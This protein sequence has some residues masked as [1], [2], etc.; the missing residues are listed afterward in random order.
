MAS[1][2]PIFSL[3]LEAG[4]AITL[5][6]AGFYTDIYLGV[7]LFLNGHLLFA[8]CV[9]MPVFLNTFFTFF[10]CFRIEKGKAFIY[11]PLILLQC[12]PQ[13]CLVRL[14]YQWG[15]K[16][17]TRDA[18]IEE[19]DKLEGGLGS[20]G[21]YI[22]SVPQA[23]VQTAFLTVAH[24]VGAVVARLCYHQKAYSCKLEH[25]SGEC[26]TFH[27]CSYVGVGNNDGKPIR[28][29]DNDYQCE[30][31]Q[32]IKG[33]ESIAQNCAN[34][35]RACIEPIKTCLTGCKIT[36]SGQID[37][38]NEKEFY[39][40]YLRGDLMYTSHFL[41]TDYNCSLHEMKNIQIHLF[42]HENKEIFLLTFVHSI[43]TE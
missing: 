21:P 40:E 37:S 38:I 26:S 20:V 5:P 41:H 36:L 1:F 3:L 7:H 18:F 42:F 2:D 33:C 17:L 24:S 30:S 23:F 39:E 35:T 32:K 11:I 6:T 14:L 10:A 34:W 9:W 22:E 43:L 25:G 16:T 8:L 27:D 28:W 4:V 29:L 13:F 31:F 19:R 12:Y 15:R